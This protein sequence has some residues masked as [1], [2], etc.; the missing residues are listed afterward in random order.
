MKTRS[1][2]SVICCLAL[3]YALG[4]C[5]DPEITLSEEQEVLF[6]VNYSN[7]AWGHQNK[8]F[9]IDKAGKV[10]TYD[11]PKDWHEGLAGSPLTTAEMDDN[12]SKT[13]LSNHTISSGEL[14][15]YVTKSAKV[16]DSAFTKPVS[17]GADMGA[18]SLFI[19]RFDPG[20][21]T[22]TKVLLQQKGDNDIFNKDPDAEDIAKWLEQVSE[23]VY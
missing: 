16:S 12:L 1:F 2:L 21:K 7:H 10:R 11:N 17:R 22:Y 5:S 6:E 14:S 23:D 18:T 13:V 9:F 3:S 19:Y 4:G 20:T 8:G 15:K